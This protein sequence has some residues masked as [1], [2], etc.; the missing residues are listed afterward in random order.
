MKLN[1][2]LIPA[3]D[4]IRNIIFD[5]GGVLLDID[6]RLSVEAFARLGLTGFDPA[7]I[8]PNNSGIFLQLELGNATEEEFVHKMQGYYIDTLPLRTPSEQPGQPRPGQSGNGPEQIIPNEIPTREQILGAWNALLLEYD[9]E[10]FRLLERL[11]TAG[12][13][14]FLLSNTNLPHRTFFVEKFDHERANPGDLP[15][16]AH[17]ERCFYSDAMHLRKPDPLIY[18]E[19]LRE[20]ALDPSETLFVD[21]N[22]PNTAAAEALGIHTFTLRPPY[23]VFDLFAE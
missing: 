20:A 2:A 14:L 21:D 23:T 9:R 18:E 13:R 16:E 19:V 10:R 11:R 17:F 7:D 8:H 5:F 3:A 1:S 4:R 15:F 22:A 12:Y 6:I